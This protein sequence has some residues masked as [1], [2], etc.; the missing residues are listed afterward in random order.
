MKIDQAALPEENVYDIHNSA[1]DADELAPDGKELQNAKRPRGW[2]SQSSSV[3]R[4]SRLNSPLQVQRENSKEFTLVEKMMDSGGYSKQ[5]KRESNHLNLPIDFPKPS[6]PDVSTKP[7]YKGTARP[8]AAPRQRGRP[9]KT[10]T[11]Q[12]Q[13]GQTSSYFT[14]QITN[15]T[16]NGQASVK[17]IHG[18]ENRVSPHRPESNLRDEFRRTD[19]RSRDLDEISSDELTN[20]PHDGEYAEAVR[21]RPEDVKTAEFNSF[22]RAQIEAVTDLPPSSIP[23][24]RFPGS[25]HKQPGPD[26]L[27]KM[28]ECNSTF[29]DSRD[30]GWSLNSIR[31][32]GHY[33]QSNNMGLVL[34]G[35]ED[36]E[37]VKEGLYLSHQKSTS[38][39]KILATK[40][41]KLNWADSSRKIRLE[42]SLVG[43][44][45]NKIDLEFSKVD[46]CVYFNNLLRCDK[47]KRTRYASVS[48]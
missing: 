27:Q 19:R 37:I 16:H 22:S 48:V 35:K 25:K 20:G 8:N 14:N 4:I 13:T 11:I 33:I 12:K 39:C 42:M 18:Y 31:I 28:G 24:S 3:V 43:N 41:R 45:D 1:E 21:V 46:D 9:S 5:S 38:N 44:G 10:S 6:D 26:R 34:E 36:F 17:E 40:L 29:K 47:V 23:H 2:N 30:S 32:D 7:P 15:D